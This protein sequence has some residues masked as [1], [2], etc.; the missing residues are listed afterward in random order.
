MELISLWTK[1]ESLFKFGTDS[2]FIPNKIC[3]TDKKLS[4]FAIELGGNEFVGSVVGDDLSIFRF[5]TFSDESAMRFKEV[6]WL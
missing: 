1:K 3:T 5:Y 6:K 2:S 4:S